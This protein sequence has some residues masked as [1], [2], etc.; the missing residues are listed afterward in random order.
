MASNPPPAFSEIHHIFNNDD[1]RILIPIINQSFEI[2]IVKVILKWVIKVARNLW[3]DKQ[4]VPSV[5]SLWYA[6]DEGHLDP[7]R[8]TIVWVI[9]SWK[10]HRIKKIWKRPPIKLLQNL[11]CLHY[12]SVQFF[13]INY[14]FALQN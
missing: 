13:I 10:C 4:M 11:H 12:F 2:G 7:L 1:G 5:F 9:S 14:H 3:T 6:V 8:S